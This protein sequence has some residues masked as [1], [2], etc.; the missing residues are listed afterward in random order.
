MATKMLTKQK[1]PYKD[2]P[3]FLHRTGQWSKKVRGRTLYFGVDSDPAL[4]KWLEQ[5]DALLAGREPK[6]HP[7]GCG[8]RDVVNSL[9][10]SK[11]ALVDT[12]ELSPRTW[13]DYH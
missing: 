2:F 8:V 12:G 1:K 10:R 5:K 3:L 4:T 7:S 13:R 9:V 11:K 6:L